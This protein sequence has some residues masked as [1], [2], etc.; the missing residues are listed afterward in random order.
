MMQTN[1]LKKQEL[2]IG[3]ATRANSGIIEIGSYVCK[4]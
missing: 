1:P 4:Y 3:D 2:E